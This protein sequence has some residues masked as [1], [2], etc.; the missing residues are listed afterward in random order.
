LVST[1][2]DMAC[3]V[4][5]SEIFCPRPFDVRPHEPIAEP[6][7]Q[8]W[9]QPPGLRHAL[10][11]T[12]SQRPPSTNSAAAPRSAASAGR[13][14]LRRPGRREYNPAAQT[15]TLDGRSAPWS[16]SA[17]RSASGYGRRD[18]S[19]CDAARSFADAV[20]PSTIPAPPSL[21][22]APDRASL[23]ARRLGIRSASA[24]WRGEASPAPPHRG[25]PSSP[26]RP[27]WPVSHS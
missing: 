16:A 8:L 24:R 19:A 6:E 9:R 14:G 11:A 3:V 5:A 21:A 15:A 2:F 4:V 22:P 13:G 27:L 25:N 12:P 26:D 17:D 1:I 23:H 7:A 10:P 20:A 18:R